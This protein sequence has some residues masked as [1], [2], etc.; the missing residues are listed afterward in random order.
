VICSLLDANQPWR[1]TGGQLNLYVYA[2]NDPIN[3]FDPYGLYVEVGVRK[4]Y[5]APVPYAKHC[6]VR[7]NGNNND[8]PSF[9][10]NG[11][12]PDPN[13]KGAKYSPTIGPENDACVRAQMEMCQSSDYAFCDFNC[14]KCVS[15]ALYFCGLKKKGPWP[16]YPC[17]A[18][19]PPYWP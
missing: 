4:F 1:V 16:N 2:N 13:P 18:G 17:D 15:N 6:F 7:F 11:V 3:F 19:D 5:P 14:C 9:D 10:I 8:T 12:Q